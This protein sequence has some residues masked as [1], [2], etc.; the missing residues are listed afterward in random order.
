MLKSKVKKFLPIVTIALIFCLLSQVLPFSA[1]G[2]E[3]Q[4]PVTK[5]GAMYA[6]VQTV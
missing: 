6:A 2:A 1:L 4:E 5:N 3:I